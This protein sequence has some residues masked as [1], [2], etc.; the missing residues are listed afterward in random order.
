M[1]K[2]QEYKV[3]ELGDEKNRGELAANIL[4]FTL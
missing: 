4:P 2:V 1:D 3:F